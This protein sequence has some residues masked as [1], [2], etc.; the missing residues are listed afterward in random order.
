[1][2]R[3]SKIATLVVLGL[4]LVE[5]PSAL[6]KNH[7]G[8]NNNQHKSFQVQSF[9]SNRSGRG[10]ISGIV[11]QAQQKKMK[12]IKVTPPPTGTYIA[13]P[14]FQVK[15][16]PTVIV[17]DHTGSSVT[18]TPIVR[19][20][21]TGAT[22]GTPFTTGG[23]VTVTTTTGGSRGG[24]GSPFGSIVHAGESLG[25]SVLDAAG[26]A[27]GGAV[28]TVGGVLGIGGSGPSTGSGPIVR[29]HRTQTG[30]IIRDHRT[31]TGPWAPGGTT[32]IV[33]PIRPPL[34]GT[35]NPNPPTTVDPGQGQPTNPTPPSN[36]T[37]PCPPQQNGN[38][39]FP[40]WQVASNFVQPSYGQGYYSQPTVA[41]QP[42]DVQVAAAEPAPA[43]QPVASDLPKLMPGMVVT[44]TTSAQAGQAAM[45]LGDLTLPV[46]IVKADAGSVT[47]RLPS[48]SLAKSMEGQ[49]I[50]AG[51][52]GTMLRTV[53][54]EMTLPTVA[55]L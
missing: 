52:D 35:A 51:S 27:V 9:L 1:M 33:D 48:L 26:S 54:F 15:T 42:A 4:A 25:N 31:V 22:G 10:L 45:Q 40:W 50:V 2:K 20:H 41:T 7:N 29:D 44:V 46:E 19:D 17:R 6:A 38:Y 30:P 43:V 32:V 24:S 11:Q 13:D 21:R 53:A 3:L 47:L 34:D 12:P 8:G 39:G 14:P 49:L 16:P 18:G 5:G 36:P 28:D 55:Q 37:P 23:G